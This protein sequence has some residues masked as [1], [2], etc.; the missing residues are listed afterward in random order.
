MFVPKLPS[1]DNLTDQ[2]TKDRALSNWKRGNLIC[3]SVVMSLFLVIIIEWSFWGSFGTYIWEAIIF[4]KILSIFVGSVVDKQLGEALLSA[5]VMTAMGLVQGIVT[6]SANDFM[7]FLLSYIVGF[8]FLII[9]RMYVGPLQTEWFGWMHDVCVSGAARMLALFPLTFGSDEDEDSP[10]SLEDAMLP[11]E[12]NETVE[13]LL[14]SYASYSCD[15]LS[16]LYTPFIMVVIMAFR[17]EVEIT[18]LYGIKEADMEYYVL[19]ALAIIPFQIIADI[20]L[21]NALELLHGWKMHEY[22]E[23]CKVRFQQ[24]EVWWKG[25]ERHTSDDCIEE[26]LRSTDQLCFSTQYYM[27]NTLHVNAIIYFVMGVEMMTRASYT[28]FGDPAMFPIVASIFLCSMAVKLIL[29][30][31]ARLFGL[32]KIKYEKRGWH[33]NVLDSEGNLNIDQWEDIQVRDHEQHMME[34]KISNETFRYKFL[35]YNKSWV[36]S[37]LPDMLTPR[38]TVNQRPYLINQ[39]ARILGQVNDDIS[40][41]SDSDD[42]PEFEAPPMTAS[43][44]TLARTWLEQANR[45]L[46]VKRIVDPL[47]QQSRGN[48]CHIC[49]ARS[50]LQV[51]MLHP[52]SGIDERYRSEYGSADIDQVLFKRFWQ[53]NQRYQTICLPCVQKRKQ[54][55]HEQIITDD[56]SSDQDDASDKNLSS[57]AMTKSAESILANWY[58]AAR[59]RV[60]P[61]NASSGSRR[62]G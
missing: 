5:P 15:T 12:N 3:S 38:V 22:L 41:D 32:W 56:R 18:T 40:S 42:G 52:I 9:E 26:S 7:D 2:Q 6:M 31:T 28:A 53:R 44:R 58:A 27:L 23:Y 47:V 50:L 24:R 29:T 13:P 43:T 51:E 61:E 25:L 1:T 54:K 4:M 14:G 39:F 11:D 20:I 46:R 49:L 59:N 35:A 17:D 45:Q 55:E 37:Q 57:E 10:D 8:G 34:Q 62:N 36:L 33:G 48:S 19:F 21:H 60:G 16:L 30:W